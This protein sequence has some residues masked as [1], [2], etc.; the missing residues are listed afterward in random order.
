MLWDAPAGKFKEMLYFVSMFCH[1]ASLD[2]LCPV[3][4][5]CPIGFLDET[6]NLDAVPHSTM[7]KHSKL[8]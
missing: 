2:L 1:S 4:E 8:E 6:V 5:I 7:A 3:G